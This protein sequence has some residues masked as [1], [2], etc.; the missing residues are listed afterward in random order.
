V[1]YDYS[2]YISDGVRGANW[3]ATDLWI[4]AV[5]LAGN[6]DLGDIH[7]IMSGEREPTRHEY[8]VL[9]HALNERYQDLGLNHPMNYWDELPRV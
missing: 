9:V 6:I 8:T 7:R 4:A 2:A 3:V 5:A 1:S